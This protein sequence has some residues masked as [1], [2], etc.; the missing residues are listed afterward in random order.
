MRLNKATSHKRR[1]K[2][3][4]IPISYNTLMINSAFLKNGLT[5]ILHVPV[6]QE[7]TM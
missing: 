7:I 2:F 5:G 4:N 1:K 3:N 6:V